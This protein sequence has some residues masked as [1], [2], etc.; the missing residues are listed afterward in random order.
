METMSPDYSIHDDGPCRSL[1]PALLSS[2]RGSTF[3]NE[4]ETET[5]TDL[6]KL[7]KSGVD[8]ELSCDLY[9]KNRIPD[10]NANRSKRTD[11]EAGDNLVHSF[12]QL[13]DSFKEVRSGMEDKNELVSDWLFDRKRYLEEWRVNVLL[14][15][16]GMFE[17]QRYHKWDPTTF[18]KKAKVRKDFNKVI[19]LNCA[20][21]YR[22]ASWLN[23]ILVDSNNRTK[24]ESQDFD[25]STLN[26]KFLNSIGEHIYLVLPTLL[27][28]TKDLYAENTPLDKILGAKLQQAE[29]KLYVTQ[30]CCK[31][32]VEAV[33]N[34]QPTH[35]KLANVLGF[36]TC[37]APH[38]KVWY[39]IPSES[40]WELFCKMFYVRQIRQWKDGGGE[41]K[42]EPHPLMTLFKGEDRTSIFLRE[43]SIIDTDV[44]NWDRQEDDIEAGDVVGSDGIPR[45]VFMGFGDTMIDETAFPC[46]GTTQL[47]YEAVPELHQHFQ[48]IRFQRIPQGVQ[49]I[50]QTRAL[51]YRS[52]L[53]APQKAPLL[54]KERNLESYKQ[55]INWMKTVCKSPELFKGQAFDLPNLS[56]VARCWLCRGIFCEYR[57]IQ[58]E[59]E[60]EDVF[61]QDKEVKQPFGRCAESVVFCG[62]LLWRMDLE[63]LY[64]V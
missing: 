32:R 5:S 41:R 25:I 2:L 48:T 20:T 58:D 38:E 14:I 12:N 46:V 3:W 50:I 55:A 10:S 18:G 24:W 21:I 11:L 40:P 61:N 34:A 13:L 26:C 60:L 6:S 57:F 17:A 63:E 7:C 19:L 29:H 37:D 64:D 54:V 16:R 39:R 51:L 45:T 47:A 49:R 43:R 28:R 36:H 9:T 22:S 31:E 1:L 42:S 27:V 8:F 56:P 15:L 52:Q 59:G 44:Q 30:Q 23:Q 35:Q 62:D 53:G 33:L 4:P